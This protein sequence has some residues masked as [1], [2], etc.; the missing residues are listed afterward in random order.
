MT[1]F[2]SIALMLCALAAC[3]RRGGQSDATQTAGDTI[4]TEARL[5]TLVEHDGWT[6]AELRNPWDE[7]AAP[8]RYA[9]VGADDVIPTLPEGVTA[10]RVPLRKS[11]VTSSVHMAAIDELGAAGSIAG[12]TDAAYVTT[13]SVKAGLA[14]GVIADAG[15]SS[16]P[17]LET[18]LDIAP[19]AV[20]ATPYAGSDHSALTKMKITVM[21][22]AD[23][24]EQ[25]PA[26]RAEW[27]RLIG[28]LYGRASEADSLYD[29]SMAEYRRLASLGASVAERPVVITEQL[30]S[31]TWYVPGG[32]SYMARLLADAGADYPFAS[33]TSAGSLAL[34]FAT[35]FDR[36]GEADYWLLKTYGADITLDG[37][38]ADYPLNAR[39]KAWRTGKVY[40]ADTAVCG[41]FEEFPFHP[42][43]LLADYLLIF[44]PEL[45]GQL[46]AARYFH[47]VKP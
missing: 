8:A 19:D 46:P 9:L 13:P 3:G 35:V 33:D 41:L 26:G 23:Y 16:S 42:E 12:V 14:S 25:T 40:A 10:V 6:L 43:R 17:T 15:T 22:M 24:M 21:E 36:A 27:I 20:L 30:T 4:T 45:A 47:R 11:V 28:R 44:H 31:G 34:D 32:A 2:V 38:K 37:L 18:I 5:L 39:M 29:V 1:R 7:H